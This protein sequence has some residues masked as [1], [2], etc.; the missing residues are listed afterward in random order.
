MSARLGGNGLAPLLGVVQV[1]VERVAECGE[2][3]WLR[4]PRSQRR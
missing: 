3:A 2:A 1:V 4:P